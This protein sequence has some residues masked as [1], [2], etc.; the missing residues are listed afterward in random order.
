[1]KKTSNFSPLKAKA[2]ARSI[3]KALGKA[4]PD[5]ACALRFANPL[6]VL[7]STILSAQCT[8]AKVNQVTPALFKRY[9]TAAD[10]ASANAKELENLIRQVGLYRAKAANIIKCCLQLVGECN[11][12]VPQDMD[13]LTA[14]AGVGRKTAACVLVNAFGKPG[15]MTDTHFCRITK[16]LGLTDETAP[17]KIERD[18]AALLPPKDWGDFSHRII[19]HGRRCCAARNPRCPECPL[20][21]HC[22]YY[23]EHVA[24][25]MGKA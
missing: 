13:S 12:K 21:K 15:L 9:R 8:D 14:L 5:A 1:M 17:E 4:Y 19:I 20:T 22:R 24:P 3:N 2:A 10:F 16:R 23:R 11:G 7:I 18:L 25:S 6:Q